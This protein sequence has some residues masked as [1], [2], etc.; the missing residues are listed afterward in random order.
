MVNVPVHALNGPVDIGEAGLI[1]FA[2]FPYQQLADEVGVRPQQRE[3]PLHLH[4]ALI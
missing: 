2:D 4:A 1:G 3:A